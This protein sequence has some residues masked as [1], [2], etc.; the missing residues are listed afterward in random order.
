MVH[1]SYSQQ[2]ILILLQV[3]PT[4]ACCKKNFLFHQGVFK[5]KQIFYENHVINRQ[6]FCGLECF[7]QYMDTYS[8]LYILYSR[9]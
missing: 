7:T 1:K 5:N 6:E 9:K 3:L 8:F 2:D 4:K